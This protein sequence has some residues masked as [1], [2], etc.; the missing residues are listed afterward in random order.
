VGIAVTLLKGYSKQVPIIVTEKVE[1]CD[2]TCDCYLKGT[3]FASRQGHREYWGLLY[4][5]S[6]LSCRFGNSVSSL[7]HRHWLRILPSSLIF[8]HP[9]FRNTDI[10]SWH[11]PI[12]FLLYQL[13]ASGLDFEN[14]ISKYFSNFDSSFTIFFAFVIFQLFFNILITFTIRPFLI[15]KRLE[16]TIFS[17]LHYSHFFFQLA[18]KLRLQMKT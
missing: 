17:H 8:G 18:S 1:Y 15:C 7:G 10:R 12:D 11:L 3:R 13:V 5:S 14:I 2:D 16:E 4:I 6:V 9:A